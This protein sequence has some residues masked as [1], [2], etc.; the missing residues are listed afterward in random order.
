MGSSRRGMFRAAARSVAR[1]GFE[2]AETKKSAEH[3]LKPPAS[4]FSDQEQLRYSRQFVLDG[5]GEAEQLNLRDASA[6][7]IGAGALGGPVAQT[8]VGAGVGRVGIVDHDA[9]EVSNLPRQ[10]LHS[11]TDIGMPKVHSAVAKLQMANTEVLVEPYLMRVEPDNVDGLIVGHDLVVDCTDA[12]DTRYLVNRACCDAGVDLVEGGV[13]GVAG[14][15]LAIRPGESACYRCAFP[16]PPPPGNRPSCAEQGLLSPAAGVV[17]SL[18]GFEALKLL[19]GW[20]EPQLD[21]FTQ[22]DLA[23]GT[24]LHVS[25]SRRADC[26]DCGDPE[27]AGPVSAA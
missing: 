7:V 9:V 2:V 26:P 3:V 24:F 6:L 5:W 13:G 10:H 17:G 11:M 12:F 20:G 8:L 21:A 19:S 15:M 22:V 14:L 4:A 23:T 25:T 16:A 27:D 1:A 18:M